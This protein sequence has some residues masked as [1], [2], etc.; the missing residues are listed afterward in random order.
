VGGGRP[1]S[2]CEGQL[3]P[4]PRRI[5]VHFHIIPQFYQD[6]VKAAGFGPARRAGYPPYA[7][8][9]GVELMD[10][11]GIAIAIFSIPSQAARWRAG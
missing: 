11:N 6:A 3:V 5:D 10:A 1:R 9:L 8:E 2:Q 4:S 7:P